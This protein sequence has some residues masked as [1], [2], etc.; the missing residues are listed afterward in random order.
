MEEAKIFFA[1]L[2]VKNFSTM[3]SAYCK[4]N[5]TRKANEL[6]RLSKPGILVSKDFDFELLSNLCV[7][8]DDKR[9]LKLLKMM[10]AMDVK[11]PKMFY[12]EVML[13]LD[14]LERCKRL[15]RFLMR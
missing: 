1:H 10:L 8:G 9:A 2:E 6:V 15:D 12:N 5:D 11:L 4:A 3:I 13:L 14:K 7:E